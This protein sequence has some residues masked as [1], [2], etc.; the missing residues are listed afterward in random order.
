[1]G[2]MSASDAAPLP[3]AGEVFFD[4]RGSSRTMRVSW[5][6]DSGIAVFS[7]WQGG[8]CTGTFRLPIPELPRMVDA[9][10]HGPAGG[11]DPMPQ[12]AEP[13]YPG[14]QAAYPGAQAA[15]PP[16][17]AMGPA[18]GYADP[19]EEHLQHAGQ[20]DMP[21]GYPQTT[22]GSFAAAE[23]GG[24]ADTASRGYGEHVPG[25]YRD[26]PAGYGAGA[27]PVQ[28][29]YGNV[30]H[31]YEDVQPGYGAAPQGYAPPG[32]E[33]APPGYGNEPYGY[34]G[35]SEGYPE[36]AP[37]AGY[38]PAGGGYPDPLSGPSQHGQAEYPARSPFAG[39]QGGPP[40]PSGPLPVGRWHEEEYAAYPGADPMGGGY[41]DAEAGYQPDP[42][43]EGMAED[44]LGGDYSGE[45]EQGYLPGP[46]TETFRPVAVG[47]HSKQAGQG[48]YQP[49]GYQPAGYEPGPAHTAEDN[50]GYSPYARAEDSASES[51]AYHPGHT[52]TRDRE[53][54]SSRG[55]S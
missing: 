31:G 54:R 40:T 45:A 6:G 41:G 10:S 24:Y 39:A 38:G 43:A 2:S 1:M 33:D 36:A 47:S 13:A 55:R 28:H 9:L 25:D 20:S 37:A 26:A 49:S 50:S 34:A 11:V 14:A 8:T 16:T 19:P 22:P 46:P 44:P 42:V 27:E 51:L 18:H 52:G 35:S 17:A 53:Y 29:G 48:P 7:I 32:Y 12:G 5:Y 30:Q 4:V 23:P 15:G 3:R 21:P